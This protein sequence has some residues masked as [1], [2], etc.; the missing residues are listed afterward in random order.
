MSPDKQIKAI[1]EA[2]GYTHIAITHTEPKVRGIGFLPN[3]KGPLQ[4]PDYL[5]DL[6]AAYALCELLAADGWS[7]VISRLSKWECEFIKRGFDSAGIARH[8]A[9]SD[10][11]ASAICEA[12]LRTLNLWTND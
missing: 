11:L 7:C 3:V 1:A 6:N 9:A 2:C 8:K 12:F 10:V 4:L 5:A